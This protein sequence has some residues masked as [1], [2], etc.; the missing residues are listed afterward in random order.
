[1]NALLR[2]GLIAL[3]CTVFNGIASL[4]G[5]G[6]ETTPPPNSPQTQSPNSGDRLQ[7]WK[8]CA[9]LLHPDSN[10][11]ASDLQAKF[12]RPQDLPQ[13]LQNLRLAEEGDWLLQPHFYDEET[14]LKFFDGSKVT[15]KEPPPSDKISAVATVLPVEV[16]SRIFPQVPVTI[17]SH[18]RIWRFKL[19]DG[20]TK[21]HADLA[22]RFLIY[23]ETFP[24]MTLRMVRSVLGHETEN[25]L[26]QG[27]TTHGPEVEPTAKGI[28]VYADRT[29]WQ[30][31]GMEVGLTFAF[32]KAP[33]PKAGERGSIEIVDDDRVIS[34]RMFQANHRSLEK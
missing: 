9:E 17:E 31:V 30:Q 27:L 13:M 3:S 5:D 34:I 14:L 2:A 10:Y 7:Q 1:M 33:P 20:H 16:D 22:G 19:N 6:A 28:V 32:Q 12:S 8:S 21:S 4:R 26:D 24:E 11:S 29:K 25:I 23:G 15:W 18:C